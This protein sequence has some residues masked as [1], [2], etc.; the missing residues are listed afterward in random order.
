MTYRLTVWLLFSALLAAPATIVPQAVPPTVEQILATY[1]QALGGKEAIQS[2]TSRVLK[3]R[4]TAP[5]LGNAQG[6]I[7][8]TAKAP[9]KQLTEIK[10]PVIGTSRTGF[11]GVEAWEEDNGKVQDAPGFIK[12]EADFYFP[13]KLRE[14]YPRLEFKGIEQIGN[15]EAY[16]L[17]APRGGSP[18]RWYFAVS[19]GLL[20]RTEV[21]DAAGKLISSEDYEDYRVVDGVKI[22]FTTRSLEDNL[23]F[24]IQFTEVKHN[25]ELAD[26]KFEKPAGKPVAALTTAE[27]EAAARVN[28]ET[29]RT[30]TTALAAKEMEGRGAG[31]AGGERAAKYLADRFA[32]LGLKPGGAEGTY[33]QPLKLTADTLL[34][35]TAF[36]VGKQTFQFRTDFGLAQPPASP[37]AL[38]DVRADVVFVGYGVVAPEI[39]RNDL[40]GL[41]VKG[42]IVLLLEGKPNNVDAAVWE[43]VARG[44]AVYRGLL[45]R[46]AAGIVEISAASATQFP[47]IAAFLSNRVV[48]LAE[49][50]PYS[51]VPARWSMELLY[52]EFQLPPTLL[53]STRAAEQIF[54]AQG[55]N[56]AQLKQQAEAGTSVS[57][58]LKVQA[59]IAPQR[60]HE[61]ASSRNLIGVLEGSDPKLKDEAVIY[62]AHY[63]AYG[64][65]PAGTIFPG[66]VDNALGVGKF[67]AIAEAFARLNPK[68]RRTIIFMAL[69]GEE[70][71]DLGA[72]Y[73]L[74]HPTWPLKNVAANI[75][76]EG[77]PL[78]LWGRT[79]FLLDYGYAHSDM[80]VTLRDL[81]AALE[82]AIVPDPTPGESYYERGDHQAFALHGIPALFLHGGP[83]ND[84]ASLLTRVQAWLAANYHMPT[85]TVQPDWNW[86][87]AQQMAAIGLLV[88]MRVTNQ[89]AMPVW[90]AA[91]PYNHP[92]GTR[93]N[94]PKK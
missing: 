8:I 37:S 5:A 49:P 6:T 23:N 20:L 73:W 91:S 70:S 86:E 15:T 61:I 64:I 50:L 7:E 14:V 27:K 48:N 46:G 56:F 13:L 83:A 11:N 29:I 26:A 74:Q 66:A 65:D 55:L 43:R 35:T 47:Q 39:N 84:V 42:K 78:D 9:N 92:R 75:N 67:L 89:E 54:A 79:E 63:D 62:T 32:A 76:F 93:I 40:A 58:D 81:A 77:N 41:N 12:R 4:I 88:G 22:A 3:G 18:K 53:L 1:V 94:L 19:T 60:K 80:Q 51:V 69:T 71:G 21:R 24:V 30:I 52:Q 44:T 28:I 82:L 10:A 33:S 38:R 45:E 34:P 85:D 36:T 68:P 59:H 90:Q 87:G 16:R 2:K 25:V 57:R 17:E 31:Q 72:D